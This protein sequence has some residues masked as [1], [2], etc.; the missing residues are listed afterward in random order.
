MAGHPRNT[1]P[2]TVPQ[3]A[4]PSQAA[5]ALDRLPFGKHIDDWP[6]QW[7]GF[8]KDLPPGEHLVQCFRPFLHHLIERQ[9]AQT[10]VRK[11][12]NNLWVLGGEIIRKLNDTPSLRNVPID[13]LVF[14]VVE[15]GGPLPYGCDSE[16]EGRSF[17]STC[18][19]LRRFLEQQ[20][21]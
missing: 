20:R 9:F 17:E 2:G 7:M 4:G 6:R 21:R 1:K 10:T 3:P 18:R 11:H 19:K 14:E 15:D 8:P 5:V 16:E 13:D 12:V